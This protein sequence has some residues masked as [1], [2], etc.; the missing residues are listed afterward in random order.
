MIKEMKDSVMQWMLYL[1]ERK[2]IKSKTKIRKE[3]H[4][5]LETKWRVTIGLSMATI[6]NPVGR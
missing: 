1:K 2:L 3:I 5:F 4:Q 6:L